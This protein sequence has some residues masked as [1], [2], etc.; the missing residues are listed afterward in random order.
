MIDAPTYENPQQTEKFDLKG[1][2]QNVKKKIRRK[3]KIKI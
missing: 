1:M 3:I 2:E